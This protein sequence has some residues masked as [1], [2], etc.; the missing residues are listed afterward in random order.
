LEAAVKDDSDD[1][2]V[3]DW[4][5]EAVQDGCS[6]AGMIYRA[7]AMRNPNSPQLQRICNHDHRTKEA[8]MACAK[9]LLKTKKV[10]DWL[11]H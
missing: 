6:S 10:V 5:P 2:P 7:Y 4:E 3:A 1:G 9:R 8:A 11:E